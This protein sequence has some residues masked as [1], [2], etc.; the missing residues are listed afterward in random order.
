[1]RENTKFERN[2]TEM[3]EL[4]LDVK[5]YWLRKKFVKLAG[6]H[7]VEVINVP[8]TAK[9]KVKK[10]IKKNKTR[11]MMKSS[12]KICHF[13]QIGNCKFGVKCRFLHQDEDDSFDEYDTDEYE[14]V[15]CNYENGDDD[16]ETFRENSIDQLKKVKSQFEDEQIYEEKEFCSA[17]QALLDEGNEKFESGQ[18]PHAL[19]LYTRGIFIFCSLSRCPTPF[20]CNRQ[21]DRHTHTHTHIR[22]VF[23]C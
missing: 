21:T 7:A 18:Y 12:A 17:V 16:N 14:D 1:V 11:D 6:K 23:V 3:R 20:L 9:S 13:Y 2:K 15:F 5:N 22:Q 4:F 8:K 19:V 10:Q